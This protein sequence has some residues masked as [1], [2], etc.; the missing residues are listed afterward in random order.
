MRL[1]SYR[2]PDYE[3]WRQAMGRKATPD[4][5]VAAAVAQIILRVRSEGDEALRALT[6][7]FDG[8]DV[9]GIRLTDAPP[10]PPRQVAAA[11]ADAKANIARFAGR[12]LPKDWRARNRHGAS[13]GEL[14]RPFERV[15]VYVPGGTAPLVSTAL[16]TVTLAK[17]A[18]C[19]QIA[20]VTPPPV[21][22]ILHYAIRLA[23]ASEIY[24]VGG[25]QAIAA[26]AFG[27]RTV[28]PVQK[29]VGPGNRYVIEAKRQIL[30]T[31]AI[32]QLPGPSEAMVI[33]DASANPA[34]VASDLLA[35]SEH[36]PD[37]SGIL[38]T[39]SLA[40][41][42]AVGAQI[43]AQLATLTRRAILERSLSAGCSL[44]HVRTLAQAIE[45]A[46][47]YAPEHISLQVRRPAALL[48]R[49]RNAGAIFLG[50][51]SPIVA[52]DFIA[53]PSHTLPTGGAAKSF[54]GLTAGEFFRRTSIIE[55]SAPSLR[56]ALPSIATFSSVEGLDAHG[57]S[58]AIRFER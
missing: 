33:A 36:G 25:A 32:D 56:R 4:A 44:A 23:G 55:Y 7:Q 3:A 1:I 21:N 9:D 29:I 42:D 52:G 37:S 10:R 47:D 17:V 14:F 8:V 39:P 43:Q 16:M 5:T 49:I 35:Q 2:D 20:V 45:I 58:A 48:S 53:G 41:R 50:A 22:P 12:Q 28:P 19:R 24:Q 34:L 40:L 27:T 18:G 38:L 13:V 30:G 46:N 57:R 54:S 11:L 31:V 51:Y 6:R 26:L 15:G